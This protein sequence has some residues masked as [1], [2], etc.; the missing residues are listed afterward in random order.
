MA[1][2]RRCECVALAEQTQANVVLENRA[3]TAAMPLS[4]TPPFLG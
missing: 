4:L 3:S 1:Q 2:A